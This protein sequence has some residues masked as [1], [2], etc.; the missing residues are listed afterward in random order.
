VTRGLEG[1]NV[2]YT[3]FLPLDWCHAIRDVAS[4][5]RASA[6]DVQAQERDDVR[7]AFFRASFACLRDAARRGLERARDHEGEIGK[8]VRCR[9]RCAT[10][11][12]VMGLFL[13]TGFD[14]RTAGKGLEARRARDGSSRGQIQP[15]RPI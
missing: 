14:V 4:A 6:L 8:L 15:L 11:E 5:L 7:S 1:R 2:R 13:R 3:G 9:R 12:L 10:Q